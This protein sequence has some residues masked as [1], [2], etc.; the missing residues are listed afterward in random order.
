MDLGDY[1]NYLPLQSLQDADISEM[2]KE[3]LYNFREAIVSSESSRLNFVGVPSAD[4]PSVVRHAFGKK[5][6][7]QRESKPLFKDKS[8]EIVKDLSILKRMNEQYN[9]NNF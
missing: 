1:N 3:A 7:L 5:F 6:N 2:V 8:K 9:L 4:V